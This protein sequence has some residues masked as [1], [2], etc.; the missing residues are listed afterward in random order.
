MK[1]KLRVWVVFPTGVKF[2]DGRA[3]LLEAIDELGSLQRAVA[4]FDMSYRSAWGYL[5]ELERA[6]GF[7]ILERTSGQGRS[8]GMKLTARGRDFLARY[9]RL[10]RSL[11]GV[12]E[13]RFAREFRAT[14]ATSAR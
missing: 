13:R 12:A 9:R 5:R 14:S 11:D 6:T 2:G 4:R 3:Q 7:P 8:S 10:R 1:P